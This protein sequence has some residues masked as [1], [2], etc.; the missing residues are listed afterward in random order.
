MRIGRLYWEGATEDGRAPTEEV[1]L[2]LESGFQPRR[3]LTPFRPARKLFCRSAPVL[4][5]PLAK[6]ISRRLLRR[7]LAKSIP[8][9]LGATRPTNVVI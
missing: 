2:R 3:V 8:V 9:R 4:G 7:P 6:A 1:S 5:R